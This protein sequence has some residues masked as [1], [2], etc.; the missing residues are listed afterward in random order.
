MLQDSELIAL[1]NLQKRLFS[2]KVKNDV[3]KRYY[4]QKNQIKDLG[5]N[6]PHNLQGFGI[7]LGW[8]TKAVDCMA[9]RIKWNGYYNP[10]LGDETL[11]EIVEWLN[12]LYHN[13]NFESEQR[14]AIKNALTTGIGFLSASKGDVDAG[15]PPVVWVAEDSNTITIDYDTRTRKIKSAFKIIYNSMTGN[16]EYGI[17]WT[18]NSTVSFEKAKNKNKWVEIDRDDH[19]MGI[20]PVVPIFNNADSDNPFGRSEITPSVQDLVDEAMRR[21]V[22]A[23]INTEYYAK[24]YRYAIN[25]ADG[26]VAGM[27]ENGAN[28]LKNA[29]G[30]IVV[31]PTNLENPNK[32]VD[33]KE[34]SANDPMAIMNTIEPLA[35]LVAR[36]I[37]VPPSDLG[38]DTVNPSSADAI[39]AADARV[40]DK[41]NDRIVELRRTFKQLAKVSLL[42]AG[43]EYPENWNVI[44][45][46]FD[47]TERMSPSAAADWL[48][49]LNAVGVYDRVLPD[50]HYRMLGFNEAEIVELKAYLRTVINTNIIDQLSEPITEVIDNTGEVIVEGE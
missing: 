2:V 48:A 24:P 50:S 27:S 35:R 5:I 28:I 4:N 3:K 13:N 42:V 47:K 6:T 49:K 38:F 12:N 14:K 11:N 26:D 31:I 8:A 37:G 41:A 40:I 46:V 30:D 39:N 20:V 19:E 44:D 23:A 25:M 7:V 32:Q 9:E 36:E 21:L 29:A 43:K 22:N 10:E 45:T 18:T 16:A 1:N 33:I 15:E 34:L 17:L